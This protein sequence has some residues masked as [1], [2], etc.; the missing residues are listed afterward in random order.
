MGKI[1]TLNKEDIHAIH[2]HKSKVANKANND[3]YI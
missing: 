3:N 2:L 1:K